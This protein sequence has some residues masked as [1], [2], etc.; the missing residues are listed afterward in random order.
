MVFE[1]SL[2]RPRN[3]V[4]LPAGWYC[5]FSAEPATVSQMADGRV[6]LVFWADG[7]EGVDVMVKGRRRVGMEERR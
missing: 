4:V 1:R 5:T 6:R 7:A 3:T 2:D